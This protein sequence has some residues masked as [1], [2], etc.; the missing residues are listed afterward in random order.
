MSLTAK[1]LLSEH[2]RKLLA[3]AAKYPT[4]AD[5]KHFGFVV[6]GP[7]EDPVENINTIEP[8]Q[9]VHMY[10]FMPDKNDVGRELGRIMAMTTMGA[11]VIQ[12]SFLTEKDGKPCLQNRNHYRLDRDCSLVF[13]EIGV[14]EPM[15]ISLTNHSNLIL[16]QNVTAKNITLTDRSFIHA[17]TNSELTDSV[18]INTH[19][20]NMSLN[21]LEPE[22]VLFDTKLSA[23]VDSEIANTVEHKQIHNANIYNTH[24]EDSN[25]IDTT[26]GVFDPKG[27]SYRP[28]SYMRSSDLKNARVSNDKQF[29]LVNAKME[30]TAIQSEKAGI[31]IRNTT[32]D[33]SYLSDSG[34]TALVPNKDFDLKDSHIDS[35]MTD[36]PL[37]CEDATITASDDNPIISTTDLKVVKRKLK[38]PDGAIVTSPDPHGVEVHLEPLRNQKVPAGFKAVNRK[39]KDYRKLA[40]LN[41]FK[42]NAE[43]ENCN[44][45]VD[46]FDVVMKEN[47]LKQNA[48]LNPAAFKDNEHLFAGVKQAA[49]ESKLTPKPAKMH[50]KQHSHVNWDL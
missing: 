49:I 31:N 26:L 43:F 21:G 34:L 19:T 25:V 28:M 16:G 40:N 14:D 39:Q 48:L 1:P 15:D 41:M 30:N 46:Q 10:S 32:L 50:L 3:N 29:K 23:F 36:H 20:G 5:F 37:V 13:D 44:A 27:H 24:L 17:A 12:Q 4:T 9:P 33:N 35:F 47:A 22:P 18:F 6:D 45:I 11:R 38:Y 7:S 8:G 2:M 42:D